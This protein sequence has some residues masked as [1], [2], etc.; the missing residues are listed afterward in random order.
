VKDYIQTALFNGGQLA[1]ITAATVYGSVGATRVTVFLSLVTF[2]ICFVTMAVTKEAMD[3]AL[4]RGKKTGKVLEIANLRKLVPP[5]KKMI[6]RLTDAISVVLLVYYGFWVSGTAI[7]L[8][9][10]FAESIWSQIE[11][12]LEIA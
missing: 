11:E 8:A 6:S 10:I 7:F 1:V 4:E 3:Q 12:R 2:L 5:W 9:A